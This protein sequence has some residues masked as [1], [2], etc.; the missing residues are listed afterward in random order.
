MIKENATQDVE[1]IETAQVDTVPGPVKSGPAESEPA[2]E[3]VAVKEPDDEG[4]APES[5]DEDETQTPEEKGPEPEKEPKAVREVKRLRR[6]AQEAERLAQERE[7]ELAYLKGKIES[8]AQP[9]Q[10]ED[11]Q[12]YEQELKEAVKKEV[13]ADMRKQTEAQRRQNIETRYKENL[14]KAIEQ[15]DEIEDK[16][17]RMQLE[18]AHP[19]IQEVIKDSEYGPQ[20]VGYLA[21]NPSEVDRLSKIAVP[22]VIRE[23]GK[24][25]AKFSATETPQQKKQRQVSQA[26]E[27]ITPTSGKGISAKTFNDMDVGDHVKKMNEHI[28]KKYG[29]L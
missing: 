25:E 2:P 11:I 3:E 1:N 18:S 12:S 17:A 6:R 23:L 7:R 8:Q 27:P 29:H 10:Q 15:N 24:I 20:I 13:M 21:D 14:A 22:S 9:E 5:T 4:P 28:W 19:D 16:V 26:P